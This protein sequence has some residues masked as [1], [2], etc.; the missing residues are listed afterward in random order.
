MKYTIEENRYGRWCGPSVVASAL[1]VPRAEAARRLTA[2]EKPTGH[3]K[4][5]TCM[6]TIAEVLGIEMQHVEREPGTSNY[7]PTVAKFLRDFPDR[8]A[9]IRASHHFIH[10]RA[11]KI[12]E[13]NNS[14]KMRGRVTHVIWLDD[15]ASQMAVQGLVVGEADFLP[16][17]RWRV[18]LTYRGDRISFV[19]GLTEEEATVRAD[20]VAASLSGVLNIVVD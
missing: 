11:G 4:G 5:T 9:I 20:A 15:T 1:A 17:G 14:D 7:L 2:I 19:Y 3:R 10:I 12:I 16:G 6:T 8:E 13:S 18:L